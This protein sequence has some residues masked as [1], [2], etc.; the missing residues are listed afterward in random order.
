MQATASKYEQMPAN[1]SKY[2]QIQSSASKYKQIQVP[3]AG[4]A[5]M[6]ADSGR[7]NPHRVKGWSPA[8]DIYVFLL[9]SV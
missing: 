9:N 1:A 4:P 7:D 3:V 6:D 2:K 5:G 8:V